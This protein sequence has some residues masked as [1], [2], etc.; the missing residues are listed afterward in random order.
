MVKAAGEAPRQRAEEAHGVGRLLKRHFAE[1]VGDCLLCVGPQLPELQV[2]AV[3]LLTGRAELPAERPGEVGDEA[4]G[5]AR[6]ERA[7]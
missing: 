6:G 4:D 5:A 3:D 7:Q 2:R 1:P